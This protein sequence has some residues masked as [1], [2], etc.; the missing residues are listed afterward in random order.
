IEVLSDAASNAYKGF[1]RRK[2]ISSIIA[3][4]YQ[5]DFEVMLDKLYTL[6][7]KRLMVRGGAAINSS[8][9]QC[10]LVDEIS[11][12]IAT[13]ANGDPSGNRFFTAREPYSS[14][15]PVGFRLTHVEDLGDSVV[16]LRYA[17]KK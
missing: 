3:G 4:E 6:R 5:I 13:I 15:S 17:V 9:L 1:L 16:W 8:F 12:I 11:S 2:R 14:V 7:I 10:G